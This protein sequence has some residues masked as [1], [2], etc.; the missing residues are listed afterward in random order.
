MSKDINDIKRKNYRHIIATAIITSIFSIIVGI[1]FSY[2]TGYDASKVHL[3]IAALVWILNILICY[4]I[5]FLFMK[6]FGAKYKYL[7]LVALSLSY[8]LS[9][10][11]VI[12]IS[13]SFDY[14]YVTSYIS[15]MAIIGAI[16]A[17]DKIYKSKKKFYE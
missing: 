11:I 16:K 13:G 10:T 1:V 4:S 3:V 2:F 6:I 9:V 7:N 8:T 5:V 17:I 14:L 12:C 15:A